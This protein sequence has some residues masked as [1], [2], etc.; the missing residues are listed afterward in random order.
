MIVL[1]MIFSKQNAGK[2][3]ASKNGTVIAADHRLSTVLRKVKRHRK[4]DIRLDLVPKT[5][6]LAGLSAL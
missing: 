5:P 3:V 4:E 1:T 2:W 6:Y